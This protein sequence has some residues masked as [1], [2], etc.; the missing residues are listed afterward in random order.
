MEVKGMVERCVADAD[1]R[2]Q[3]VV[4]TDAGWEEIRSAAPGHVTFVRESV[5]DP[6]SPE[7]QDQ[8]ESMLTRIRAQITDQGLWGRMKLTAECPPGAPRGS[9]ECSTPDGSDS[10]VQ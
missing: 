10:S 6:L 1:G 5:F 7:E 2:G 9:E 8:L 3:D 4:L